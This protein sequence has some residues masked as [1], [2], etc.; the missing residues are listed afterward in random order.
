MR[1]DHSRLLFAR[2]FVLGGSTDKHQFVLGEDEE[3]EDVENPRGMN[4]EE[5]EEPVAITV[6]GRF[7]ECH[8]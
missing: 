7:P 2:F 5:S 6:S 1:L 8:P 3:V 4:Q